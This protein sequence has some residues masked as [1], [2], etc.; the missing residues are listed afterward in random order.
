MPKGWRMRK[1]VVVRALIGVVSV[2]TIATLV[3]ATAFHFRQAS[4]AA[5]YIPHPVN[6]SPQMSPAGEPTAGDSGANYGLFTCQ[7]GLDGGVV[8]Y[9]PYQMRRA[10]QIRS[11]VNAGFDGTGKTIVI[12]DAF[13]DPNLIADVTYFDNFYG[14]PP[15]NLQVVRLTSTPGFDSGWAGETTLDVEWAHAIAPGAKIVLEEATTNNDTDILAAL[16]D[17]VNNNRGD[18]ISQSFGENETCVDPGIVSAQHQVYANATAKGVTIFAS[19]G[20]N[21][22]AQQTCDNKSWTQVA[23]FPA[24]DPLVTAVGGTE[25]HASDYCLTVLGCDPATNPA[26]GTYQSE[27]AWNEPDFQAATGGGYSKVYSEPSYQEGTIH[28]GKQ[29]AVPDVAYN[30]AILHGVLVRLFGHWYLF[31]GT[32]CGSPQWAAILAITD[33]VAGHDLGSINEGLYHIGQAQ[34]HYATGFHD[35]LSGN[36]SVTE[37]DTSN[38]PV[39]VQGFDSSEGWD[40]TTGLGSPIVD[41]LVPELITWA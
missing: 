29:R 12:V 2:A 8:C 28:G 19:T 33:Q 3:M 13:D 14:L 25:L 38:N 4:A 37:T 32:S 36:N 41:Q 24:V 15:I 10:Y 21:G 30:G 5:P 6:V 7:V 1:R 17:A 40:A 35:V 9:D 34:Q 39:F 31:G 23:S 22:A 18:V 11:L 16:Q 27:V 20:D 26:A